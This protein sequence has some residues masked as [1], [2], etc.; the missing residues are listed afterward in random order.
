MGNDEELKFAFNLGNFGCR[1]KNQKDLDKV[2]LWFI[3]FLIPYLVERGFSV[4]ILL[5]RPK[6]NANLDDSRFTKSYTEQLSPR[7]LLNK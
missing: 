6:I 7:V 2:K 5:M 4:V 3:A 1:Q